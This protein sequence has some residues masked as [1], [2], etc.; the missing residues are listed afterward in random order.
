M[1]YSITCEESDIKRSFISANEEIKTNQIILP[2][3]QSSMYTS[4]PIKTK[5]VKL[6]YESTK[7]YESAKYKDSTMCDLD[8][9]M[10]Q[11]Y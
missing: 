1:N 3:Y 5:E 4:K 11:L 7:L 2:N 6:A 8:L 9:D 10:M